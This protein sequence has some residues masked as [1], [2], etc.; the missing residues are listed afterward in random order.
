MAQAIEIERTETQGSDHSMKSFFKT[1]GNKINQFAGRFR[2][3]KV[4]RDD[5][6]I[7]EVLKR[8]GII[9]ELQLMTALES[10]RELLLQKGRAVRLGRVIVDLGYARESDVI[11]TINAEYQIEVGSLADDIR[12]LLSQKYGAHF[13]RLPKSRIPMWAQ[14]A[15]ATTFVVV[16]TIFTLSMVVLDEQKDRLYDQTVRLGMVSLSYFANNASIPLLEDDILR[17]NTLIK[18]ASRVEG[19][20]YALITDAE[21]LIKA[22]TDINLIGV[23]FK[24]F[25]D[26]QDLMRKED[27]EYY[28]YY[29]PDGERLLN[30][31]RPIRFK[32]KSLGQVHVGISLNFIEDLVRQER[33]SVVLVTLVVILI[34]LGIAVLYG[35]RFS[36]PISQ[37]VRATEEIAK[38]NYQYRV[39][40]KRN[41]E[42]GNLATAF[43]NMGQE[44]WKNSMTQ[45]SF[46]KYVGAEVLDMILANPETN[47]LKGTRND[48]TIVFCDVR[49]FTAYATENAPEQVVEALNTYLEI[50]TSV[51]IKQGGYIDK[52]IGDAVMGVFGVPVFRQDHVERAVRAAMIVQEQLHKKSRDGNKLLAAVGISIHTGVVVA[53]NVGSQSKMEYTVIGD[54]V[55]VAA[56]LNAVAGP[57]EVVVSQ[58]V[59]ENLKDLIITEDLGPQTIK[60]KTEPISTFKVLSVPLKT[61]ASN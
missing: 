55:N 57:G 38:G 45:K 5:L 43:N 2:K 19:L 26:A 58:Q 22:H 54:S 13:E 16:L 59:Q 50:A 51:I 14:L 46:G 39:P 15:V 36:R 48:A 33:I 41:D 31:Y 10:Q 29:R 12:H 32:D 9:T 27:V 35:F 6:F 56:R 40:I 61:H 37:L 30:L 20:R 4:S 24:H 44:L 47:W 21:G 8:A 49:G 42:L 34:G 7:G 23:P 1:I 52:F 18:E 11:R 3:G 53:G 25:V 60:G 17:L 28:T